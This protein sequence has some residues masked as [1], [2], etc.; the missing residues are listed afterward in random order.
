MYQGSMTKIADAALSTQHLLVKFGSDADHIAVAGASDAP[1]GTCADTPAA[2]D[3]AAVHLLGSFPGSITMVA[4]E[5]I[6]AGERVF[7]A[8]GGEVSTLPEANGD[9]FCVGVA[10]T[11]GGDGDEIE[12]DSCVPFTVTVSG[13]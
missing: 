12:V 10:L 3:S 9:Y 8:A 11:G 5:T 13:S 4:S 7:A 2:D 1:I 6:E